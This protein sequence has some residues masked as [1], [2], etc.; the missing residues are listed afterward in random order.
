MLIVGYNICKYVTQLVP[1]T[2]SWCGLGA[3][4]RNRKFYLKILNCNP[5]RLYEE[6]RAYLQQEDLAVPSTDRN[7]IL[8]LP[9]WLKLASNRGKRVMLVLDA[10]N[11]LDCGAG[12]AG[13]EHELK[14]LP[15]DLPHNVYL[16]MSTLPGK[17]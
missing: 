11:Q 5:L 7:L 6:L 4:N 10:L 12:N 14:W 9:T 2:V 1:I 3:E 17:V 15:K 13:E 16:L 8:E